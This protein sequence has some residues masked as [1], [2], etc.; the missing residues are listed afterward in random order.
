MGSSASPDVTGWSASETDKADVYQSSRI[1]ATVRTP[2]PAAPAAVADGDRHRANTSTARRRA[3]TSRSR[4]PEGKK[5]LE[6]TGWSQAVPNHKDGTASLANDR[7]PSDPRVLYCGRHF[8]LAGRRALLRPGRESGRL[9]RSSRPR[10]PLLAGLH[11]S[12]C[13]QLLRAVSRDQQGLWAR[14]GQPLE[15][16]DR[17][18]L[19]RADTLDLAK[20]ATGCRFS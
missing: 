1:V 7:R 20:S 10:G 12:G 4:T 9:S 11:G 17:A 15:D 5:L 19:Q 16:H 13:A 3:R 8:C 14:V 6:M 2:E 18:G